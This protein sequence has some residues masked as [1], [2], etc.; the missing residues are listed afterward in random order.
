[1]TNNNAYIID[2]PIKEEVF[3]GEGQTTS[4]MQETD[5]L[6]DGATEPEPPVRGDVTKR[7]IANGSGFV[8]SSFEYDNYG[9]QIRN[10]DAN[11]HST[12]TSFDPPYHL[13][14][15]SVCDT[16]T[17]C[18]TYNWNPLSGGV[19]S[20]TDASEATITSS[21]DV[22]GRLIGVTNP[23]GGK[24]I[25]AYGSVENSEGNI[26]G[27]TIRRWTTDKTQQIWTDTYLDGLD[28]SYRVVMNEG[29]ERDTQYSDA[30]DRPH[31][32]SRWFTAQQ[33]RN[34]RNTAT[35]DSG[36]SFPQSSPIPPFCATTTLWDQLRSTVALP[37]QDKV[38][39]TDAYG[40]ITQVQEHNGT[41]IT[42][43]YAFD[44]LGRIV[45]VQDSAGNYSIVDWDMLG[46]RRSI[47]DPDMG[48]WHYTY[49]SVGN[50]TSLIDA[51][52]QKLVFAYDAANRRLSKEYADGSKTL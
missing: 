45:R 30:T 23:D 47:S 14:P 2:L 43:S 22:H 24:I 20:I 11:G 15:A 39:K 9:N 46:H 35:M 27:Q 44:A 36:V 41:Y 13:F 38:F 26:T 31:A 12:A 6:Y 4:K 34:G 29:P 21:Y 8:A 7:L 42:T 25:L 10:T 51:K 16:L 18:S 48:T 17:H 3:S 1:M 33:S 40:R 49:D 5:W 50:L 52:Q 32:E 28:R 19:A 37:G